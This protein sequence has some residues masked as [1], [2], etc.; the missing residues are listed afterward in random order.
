[1]PVVTKN[2]VCALSSLTSLIIGSLVVVFTALVSDCKSG[3]VAD[4]VGS[5]HPD[6]R[7]T[8]MAS[9]KILEMCL[10]VFINV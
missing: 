8:G 7:S 5:E 9:V 2:F 3:G 6:S 10:C 1:M 4:L